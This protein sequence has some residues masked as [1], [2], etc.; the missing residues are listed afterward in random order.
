MKT[1]EIKRVLLASMPRQRGEDIRWAQLQDTPL[2]P[3]LK[4]M[5]NTPQDA[6]H[7]AEGDVLTHTKAVCTA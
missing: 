3:Y 4:K 6:L 2:A 1:N 5:Q 7:H